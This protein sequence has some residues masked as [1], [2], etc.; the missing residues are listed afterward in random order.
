VP[1]IQEIANLMLLRGNI[2]K[3]GRPVPGARPQ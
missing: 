2:G 1:T 3:P